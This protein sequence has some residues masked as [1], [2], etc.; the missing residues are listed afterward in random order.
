MKVNYRH[1]TRAR[2]LVIVVGLTVG[3]LLLLFFFGR[4]IGSIGSVLTRPLYVVRSWIAE[5]SAVLP[6]YIRSRDELIAEINALKGDIATYSGMDLTVSRL[7]EENEELRILLGTTNED[8]IIASV[9]ARP[10]YLPYDGIFIDHGTVHGILEGAVVYYTADA[11]IGYVSRV[12]PHSALVTLFSNP[13]TTASVFL[14]G[15]NVFATAV[16]EGGGVVSIGV[17]QGVRVMPGDAVLL[18][19]LGDGIL[20]TVRSV[21]S[22]PTEPE[23]QAFVVA[24]IPLQSLRLVS[25]S[26]ETI[27]PLSY[28]EALGVLRESMDSRFMVDDIPE[29]AYQLPLFHGSTSGTTTEPVATTTE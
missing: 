10:P 25:I 17:P 26:T 2:P 22:R 15:P 27:S 29:E 24:D 1:S 14:T 11:V 20:G 12:F 3:V 18:P 9:I 4:T 13:G 23:Q 6:K 8:R 16:G 5:S 21:D 19:S 7:S 28:E